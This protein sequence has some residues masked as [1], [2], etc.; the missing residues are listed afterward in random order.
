MALVIS[1]ARSTYG[2]ATSVPG[3]PLRCYILAQLPD[4]ANLT[5]VP[6]LRALLT[7]EE[8]KWKAFQAKRESIQAKKALWSRI[9]NSMKQATVV[10]INPEKVES[11]I[12]EDLLSQ[13]AEE[14]IDF[15]QQ[16]LIGQCATALIAET[17]VAYLPNSLSQTLGLYP[18]SLY[19][20]FDKFSPE[21]I[22][23]RIGGNLK[24]AKVFA[25]RAHATFDLSSQSTSKGRMTERFR[26]PGSLLVFLELLATQRGFDEE[27]PKSAQVLNEASETIASALEEAL[28]LPGGITN[29]PLVR[30]FNSRDIDVLQAADIASGWAHELVALGNENAL[31]QTFWRVIL[32]GE[33]LA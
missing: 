27:H 15:D 7:I 22:K 1:M 23:N 10:V 16:A 13:G 2:D 25:A 32:N 31:G 28:M 5:W 14:G 29:E 17:P 33:L 20:A 9:L 8:L 11:F 26:K 18:P 21:S 24:D 3:G 4:D 6:E 30:E 12:R 19:S